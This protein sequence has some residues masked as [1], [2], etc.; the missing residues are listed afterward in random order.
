M[1]FD[2]PDGNA[3]L[4]SDTFDA[5]YQ[6]IAWNIYLE[7]PLNP[8]FG[9]SAPELQ[10]RAVAESTR[11]LD[12]WREHAL[13]GDPDLLN[14]HDGTTPWRYLRDA[15]TT[16]GDAVGT[17]DTAHDNIIEAW[18]GEAASKYA[19][20]ML[21]MRDRIKN[22]VGEN[23]KE[24]YLADAAALLEAAYAVQ[25]AF[26]KDLLELARAANDALKG[27]DDGSVSKTIGLLCIALGG[28]ALSTLAA[29]VGA[30][31]IVGAIFVSKVAGDIIGKVGDYAFA[32]AKE[33]LTISGDTAESIMASLDSGLNQ[34]IAGYQSVSR[35]ITTKMEAVLQ[36]LRSAS[37]VKEDY[38]Q[39]P[40][41]DA[42]TS[43]R[44]FLPE[45]AQ[46]NPKI[47]EMIDHPR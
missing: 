23:A 42:K 34:A 36:D 12:R 15:R 14:S 28:I 24:G 20:Y 11:P 4:T 35:E 27:L 19:E 8:A 17:L 39:A 18:T 46:G 37:N 41:V 45:T 43:L 31:G 1:A 10:R 32:Q 30:A 33:N 3:P 7:T 6:A 29:S 5:C 38:P 21:Q 25:V 22:H 13:D 9:V 26:K 40:V 47:N 16:L 44:Q 2:I